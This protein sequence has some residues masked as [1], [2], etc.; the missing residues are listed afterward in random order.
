MDA[1]VQ[2]RCGLE[3]DGVDGAVAVRA[4]EPPAHDGSSAGSSC[5]ADHRAGQHPGGPAE[6]CQLTDTAPTG[7]HRGGGIGRRGAVRS[8]VAGGVAVGAVAGYVVV[9]GEGSATMA[10][11]AGSAVA[12][13]LPS[14]VGTTSLAEAAGVVTPSFLNDLG[15][16][17]AVVAAAASVVSTLTDLNLVRGGGAASVAADK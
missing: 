10:A 11:D 1:G 14:L 16:V 4:L 13:P 6:R 15:D 5:M 3:L 17:A 12:R 8:L 9:R 2:A 7:T